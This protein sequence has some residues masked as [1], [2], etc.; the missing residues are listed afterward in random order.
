M[1]SPVSESDL[2]ALLSSFG[3]KYHLWGTGESKTLEHLIEEL[4]TGESSLVIVDQKLIWTSVC[5]SV[6]IT[7]GDL[8]LVEDRQVFNDGRTRT[9]PQHY[10]TSINEKLKPGENH[11]EGVVR[12]LS[13]E[14]G[15]ELTVL[16][17]PI[18]KGPKEIGPAPSQSYPELL[19]RFTRHEY[20]WEMSQGFY[21]PEGYVET[22]PDKTTYFI[23][24][25]LNNA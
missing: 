10:G 6:L 16:D 7:Y 19:S 3:V 12:A 17:V 8:T 24:K 23:W 18:Y 11:Y 5:A 15:I 1:H 22:Q 25:K 13:E 20:L 9:R 14:L 4:A 21:V 2:R